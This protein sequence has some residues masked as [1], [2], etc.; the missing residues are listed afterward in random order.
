VGLLEETKEGEKEGKNDRVSNTS[1]LC[2]N[3]YNKTLKT[4]EQHRIEGKG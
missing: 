3:R 2:R 4:A 1:Y